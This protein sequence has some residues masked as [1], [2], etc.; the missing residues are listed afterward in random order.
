MDERQA[1]A[2]IGSLTGRTRYRQNWRGKLILQVEFND[3]SWLGHSVHRFRAWRDATLSDI[4][5]GAYYGNMPSEIV[6]EHSW[7][8]GRTTAEASS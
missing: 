7:P 3:S 4:Y 6:R 2:A 8:A 1:F 5:T